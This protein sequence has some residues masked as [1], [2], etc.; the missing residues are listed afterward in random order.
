MKQNKVKIYSQA[1]AEVLS[2]PKGR[3]KIVDNFLKLLE[4]EGLQARAKEIV[5][6]AEDLLLV[7]QGKHRIVF[8]TA[9]EI[10]AGQKKILHEIAKQGDIIKEKINPDLIAGVKITINS[11]RQFDASMLKKLENTF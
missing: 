8:E 2:E 10:T 1:L 4:K 7:K 9:R 5:A 11:E 6:L 3:E